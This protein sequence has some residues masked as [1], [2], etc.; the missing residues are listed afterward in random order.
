MLFLKSLC[1]VDPVML[2]ISKYAS[3]AI[4]DIRPTIV[5]GLF[6]YEL[7]VTVTLSLLK[8]P[9]ATAMIIPPSRKKIAAKM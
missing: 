7:L 1:I 3:S 9:V 4:C 5:A 2:G 8:T 6:I